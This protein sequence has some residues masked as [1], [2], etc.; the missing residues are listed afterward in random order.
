MRLGD[1]PRRGQQQRAGRARRMLRP[2]RHR[3]TARTPTSGTR[4][5]V[6][7]ISIVR[8]AVSPRGARP[9][10]TRPAVAAILDQRPHRRQHRAHCRR[11]QPLVAEH[12]A[13]RRPAGPSTARRR[14]GGT[15][16]RSASSTAPHTDTRSTSSSAG[17]GSTSAAPPRRRRASGPARPRPGPVRWPRVRAAA[18]RAAADR[19]APPGSRHRGGQRGVHVAQSVDRR[20]RATSGVGVGGHRRPVPGTATCASTGGATSV[21]T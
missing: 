11:Q 16:G 5:A 1:A 3:R 10:L 4:T 13:R 9:T 18:G 20:R 2:R 12:R 21:S 19:A 6:W 8:V 14:P 7:A 17:S 15:R